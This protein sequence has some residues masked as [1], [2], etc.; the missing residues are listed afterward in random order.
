[1]GVKDENYRLSQLVDDIHLFV[2]F[3]RKI[4]ILPLTH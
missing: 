4:T 1:M 3:V 2:P